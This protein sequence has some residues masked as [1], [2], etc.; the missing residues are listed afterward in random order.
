[1]HESV[2]AW[3]YTAVL[4]A[5]QP[6][7]IPPKSSQV[8]TCLNSFTVIYS[9]HCLSCST[10]GVE[11]PAF[12]LK[13]KSPD[14]ESLSGVSHHHHLFKSFLWQEACPGEQELFTVRYE[15]L[16]CTLVMEG[17]KECLYFS[18]GDYVT[19]WTKVNVHTSTGRECWRT[20]RSC[21]ESGSSSFTSCASYWPDRYVCVIR[22][23]TVHLK[24]ESVYVCIVAY[25][26]I[27]LLSYCNTLG[28]SC[29]SQDELGSRVDFLLERCFKTER[30]EME[31]MENVNKLLLQNV[32]P[33]HVASFFM[34][35]TIRNQVK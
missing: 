8:S 26:Q 20:L 3:I 23:S 13:L 35:K 34:G 7:C 2:Q 18:C 14:C 28:S 22:W 19:V 15:T 30:E 6:L 31:T 29:F 21:P 27:I 11:F 5:T 32:L 4:I 10:K 1:M 24:E 25:V 16:L 12:C 9:H 17:K 33:L